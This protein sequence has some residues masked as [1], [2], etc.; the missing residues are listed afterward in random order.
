MPEV[1]SRHTKTAVFLMITRLLLTG[2]GGCCLLHSVP[3][4]HGWRLLYLVA[5]A[6]AVSAS[7]GACSASVARR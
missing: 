4:L 7:S 2:A 6:L 5:A 1:Q 3:S